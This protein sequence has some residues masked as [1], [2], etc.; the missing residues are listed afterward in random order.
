[1]WE[2]HYALADSLREAGQ[3]A[4]AV[5]EYEQVVACDPRTA[6]RTPISASASG[7]PAARRGR[8][9]SSVA[10]SRSIRRSRAATP[11]SARS[12]CVTG[13]PV[14]RPRLLSR[15]HREGSEQRPRPHAAREPLRE[16]LSRLPFGGP[17]VRRSA[18]RSRPRLRA[19]SS[20]S[21]ATSGLRQPGRGADAMRILHAIHDFLPRHRAGSEIYAFELARE[22]SRR[23]TTCSSSL[24]STIP[25]PLTARSA[26]VRHDGLPSSRS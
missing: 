3:C 1:M 21:N 10:R 16:D 18:S 2:P 17:D 15:G 5:A 12:R 8:A 13:D 6:T 4:A 11:T 20:A 24:R 19:W 26:G 14:A 25:P 22:L 23:A 7:R 9:R